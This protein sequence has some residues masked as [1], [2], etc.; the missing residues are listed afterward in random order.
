MKLLC[1]VE[2]CRAFV[3]HEIA[4]DDISLRDCYTIILNQSK[5][6]YAAKYFC[7][8]YIAKK[9]TNLRFILFFDNFI[10]CYQLQLVYCIYFKFSSQYR[11]RRHFALSLTF[12]ESF[13]NTKESVIQHIIRTFLH[14]TRISSLHLHIPI[15]KLQ[16]NI[17]SQRILSKF[18]DFFARICHANIMLC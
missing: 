1:R 4:F 14:S 5:N 10:E 11:S 6:K 17:Y 3:S 13:A 2:E 16:K 7:P 8:Y 15:F 12:I 9:P 18:T